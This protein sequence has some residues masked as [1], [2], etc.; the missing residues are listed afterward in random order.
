MQILFLTPILGLL[1]LLQLLR[2]VSVK[3]F[4][5]KEQVTLLFAIRLVANAYLINSFPF[6][7]HTI[8]IQTF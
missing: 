5:R 1:M 2:L 4:K 3:Y 7:C 6:I 8:L